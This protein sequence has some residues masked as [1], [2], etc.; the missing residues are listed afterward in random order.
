MTYPPLRLEGLPFELEWD[1]L[2]NYTIGSS[3]SFEW[4]KIIFGMITSMGI[5]HA[6]A[7]TLRG[8]S[9]TKLGQRQRERVVGF[10]EAPNREGSRRGRNAEG[11]RPSE[12]EARE[13][14][15]RGVNLSPLSAAHLGRNENGQPLRSSLTSVYGGHQPSTNIGGNLPPNG[16]LLLYHAQPFIPS[17]LH[18]PTGLVPIHVNPY[19]Q[20][21]AG[22]VNGQT[23]NFPFQTQVGNPLAGGISTYHPQGGYIPQ[24]FTNNGVPSYNGSMYPAATP[25]SN[26]PFY[27]QPMYAPPNMLVYPNLIGSF[28]D[29]TGFVTPFARWIEDYPLSD[30]LKMPSHIGSYD[31]KRDPDNFLHLFEG[32]IRMQKW[33]MPV[34]CYMFTYTLKDSARIWRNSQKTGSILNYEDLK[35]KFRSHFSQQKKYTNDILQI[36]GLH[37]EQRISGFLHGLRT[38]TLVEYLST[39]LPSTYKGLMEKTYTWIE[40]REVATNETPN[41]R[42][43]NFER[44]RKSSWDNN[45]GQKGRDRFSPYRG[46]NHGLLSNL[47]KSPREIIATEKA[48]RS[49]EQPPR[50]FGSRRSRDISKYCH[51]HEDHEHDTNDYCQLRN[52]IEEAVKS[53]QL[54]HLVKGIKK[55]RDESYTKNKFKGLTSEGKEITF[56]SGGEKS[57]SIGKI[58]LEITIGDPPLTRKETLNF[59]IIKSDSPYNMLLGRTAMQKMGFVVST[60]HGAI[61]FHTT[62]GIGTV[63]LTYESDKVK[64]GMKK[65]HA[66]MIGIPRNITVKGNPFNT[67]HKLNEYSHVK[68]IKQKRRGLGPD[69]STAACKEVEELMKAGILRKVNH[70]IWVANPVMVKKSDRGWRMCVDFTDI[71]K[72]C[73]KDC[74]PLPEI[75]WKVESLSGFRL[76]CFLDAYKGYHQIQMAEGD[77]D[78]T[79]FFAGEGVFCYRKMPFGLKNAGATYQRLVDKVFH[80]QIGRNLEAYVDDMVIKSTSEE[81]MLADIKDT[82][83]KFRSINMKLN[84]KK[85]SFGV[86]EGPF[87]GHLITKQGIRANPSKP[88]AVSYRRASKDPFPSSK[89]SKAAQIRRTYNG[90]KKQSNT[91]RNKEICGN[92]ANAYGNSTRRDSDDV[93]HSLDR[94]HKCSFVHK[95]GRRTGSHL[96]HKQSSIGAELNY[97]GM[98]KLILAL[99]HATRRLQRYFQAGMIT[100]LTN[101]PIK[102]TLTKPKKIRR[103]AK[104]AI[105]LGEHDIVFQERGDEIP[106]D[107]QIE[108]PLED[109]KKEA[110][111]K[112]DTK[113]TKAELSCEWKLFTDEAASSDGSGA[114][115]MLIDPREKNIL[116]PYASDLKQQT[117]KQNTKHYWPVLPKRSIEE[118]EIIQVETKEGESWMTP[119]HEYLVN[120][121][122]P[123]DPKESKKIRVKAPQYKLIRGNISRRFQILGNSRRTLHEMGGSKTSDR[124]KRKACRKIRIGIRSVQIRSATNNQLKGQEAFPRRTLLRNSQ[125]ETPFSLT[126]GFKVIIPIFENDVAKDDKGRIKEVDKRRGSKEIASIKEAYYRRS[127]QV[128]QGPHMISEVHGGG[129]YKIVDAYD[130]FDDNKNSKESTYQA[131]EFY[132]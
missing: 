50:M 5:R 128:W 14:K 87:L 81:E 103:V 93:P 74:Y 1:P 132:I 25:S 78:K 24:T 13:D 125:N 43:E 118:K 115:L 39:D 76:K 126:Y 120:G 79:A 33:L 6:K 49:F 86:E 112:A 3:N 55:E 80:D 56:P 54:S 116:M 85:C 122:L 60:F 28:A 15:N 17:S 97:R 51:F 89:Y 127:T 109:N 21:S 108:V 114:G 44:S 11:I 82:F 106:K 32:A 10:E 37:E 70:Q 77:E 23:L 35:A 72:A 71:N 12:I 62:K 31:G 16:T 101:S 129:L 63:F 41:D 57:W 83:E 92:T 107:F 61:E 73:P 18:T 38:R 111:E 104:W 42:R 113:P 36:L 105:E 20:P 99:V 84:P 8:R 2:P 124:Y 67:E 26:Y 40:A 69:R 22:L 88:S 91:L 123:E 110:E 52:Q 4:R 58:P 27:T 19:S 102:Q 66:D 75:D 59:A 117:T 45:Q 100:V 47:S 96:L 98:E 90:H 131:S 95:N 48:A 7:Y 9:S 53:G 34:A 29:S 46:P 30:G 130:H 65:T 64:E 121:L 94:E 119:I 68:P